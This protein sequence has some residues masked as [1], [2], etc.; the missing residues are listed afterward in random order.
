MKKILFFVL[1]LLLI[2]PVQ[3]QINTD[4]VL[5]IGRNA[6]YFEDYVLSIQYFNQV[7]RVKPHLAEPYFYRAVAKY[8]LDDFKG[9]EEDATLCL[10]RNQFLLNAYDLRGASRQNMED[11]TGAIEDYRKGLEFNPESRQL[12]FKKAIA[13]LQ[14]KDYEE[15]EQD[16]D[17]LIKY[18]PSY[19]KA[20]LVRS[21]LHVEKKDTLAAIH[22]IEILIEKDKHFAPAYDQRAILYF[23]QKKYEQALNDLNEAIRL[24]TKNPEYYIR[25]GLIRYYLNDLRGA[26]SDYDVSVSMNENNLVARFNRGLLRAQVGDDNNAITDFDA[27]LQQDPDNYQALYNR[28]LLKE[29]I[30]DYRGALEDI[31]RVQA[32]YPHFSAVYY[33][34]SEIK[35]KMRDFR[36]AEKDYWQAYEIQQKA[37]KSNLSDNQEPSL[38]E[39][40]TREESD[41]TIEKFNRLVVYDKSEEEKAKYTNEIRGRVQDKQVNVNLEEPFVI[42]Y[43]ERL[44]DM[45]KSK[46][47]D[48]SLEDQNRQWLFSLKLILTNAEAPLTDEQVEKHFRSIDDFSAQIDKNPEDI[49]AYFG[50][51]MDF[52]VLKDLSSAIDDFSKVISLNPNFTLAYFNRAV[53]SYKQLEINKHTAGTG[54]TLDNDTQFNLMSGSGSKNTAAAPALPG[55]ASSQAKDQRIYEYEIIMRDYDKVI[56]SNPTFAFAHFN[57]GNLLAAQKDFT[58]AIVDYTE[59]IRIEPELAEAYFNRGLVRLFQGDRK[60]GMADLSKAGELGIVNAYGIIKR[61]TGE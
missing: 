24:E 44:D 36:G 59:A 52:M 56:Q 27:V 1:F 34:R 45:A 2:Y 15:A 19:L 30:G 53:V 37:N 29:Q 8:N 57:R 11:Y 10:A 14:R 43:Y 13:Q 54:L 6:L 3:S 4:R 33:V 9:A 60:R 25:R 38:A 31:D 48:K 42:S 49:R 46:Y 5:S 51:G 40:K 39:N 7:I 17:L 23:Y 58:S 20:F 16:I 22:D 35:K 32:Q 12:L 18:H 41:K 28:G 26:M 61:M 21:S 47:Y 50:R 55:N